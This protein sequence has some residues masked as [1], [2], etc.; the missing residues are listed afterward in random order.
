MILPRVYSRID[1]VHGS[2]SKWRLRANVSKNAVIVFS[3]A[4]VSGEWKWGEHLLPRVSN[5]AYLGVN[6]AS[7]AAWDI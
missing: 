2:C 1:T 5:Y 6:L 4:S 3:K 7:N